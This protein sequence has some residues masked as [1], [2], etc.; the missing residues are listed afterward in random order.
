MSSLHIRLAA[1]NAAANPTRA[2]V[3][4][5]AAFGDGVACGHVDGSIW[6]YSLTGPATQPE[7]DGPGDAGE[8]RLY[9]KCMLAGHRAAIAL[10]SLAE[11]SS[12]TPEGREGALISVSEDGDVMVWSTADGQ[13]ISRVQTPLS[14]IRP[15][16]MC[17]QATDYQS[18]AEN[19]L[20]IA[21]E[22]R[23]AYVLSYPSLELVHEWV[24]P[25]PEWITALAVRKRRDWFRTELI[26]CASDG[27]VRIW[28][29]D[30][31]APAQQD[32]VSRAAS[33]VPEAQVDNGSAESEPQGRAKICLESQFAALGAESAIRMLVVNPFNDDEFLAVSPKTVRLFA[34][35]SSELHELLRWRPQRSTESSFVGG[36]FLAKSDIIFWDAA[37]TIY[38][39][40]TLFSIEGGSAGMHM[41]RGQHA[42]GGSSSPFFVAAGLSAVLPGS[43]LGRAS[44]QR[45][46]AGTGA[47]SVLATYSSSHDKHTLSL[48][49]PVPLSSVSGSANR[50]HQSPADAEGGPRNWLGRTALFSMGPLWHEWLQ[51]VVLEREITSVLAMRDGC[52]AIGHGDGTIQMMPPSSLIGGL[53][54]STR[55]K[56]C[57]KDCGKGGGKDGGNGV[58]VLSGHEGAVTALLEWHPPGA[59]QQQSRESL[60]LG[61]PERAPEP[62][63][64]SS[65]LISA[66]KDLA[67]RIWSVATGECLYTL[68]AQSAPVEALHA[69]EPDHAMVRGSEAQCRTLGGLLGSLV[70]AVGS[71][72]S[73]TLV[74]V[75]SFERVCVTAPYRARPVR[76]SLDR[77]TGALELQYSNNSRRR[78]GADYLAGGGDGGRWREWS[79]NL[80]T[81]PSQLACGG[82]NDSSS[83]SGGGGRWL[84]VGLL[85]PRG[86]APG[87]RRQPCASAAVLT[88]D[89]DVTQ[90]HT[91]VSRMVG[92]GVS[93][94]EM[95]QLLD[96]DD[97]QPLRAS[98]ELL[99]RLC[100]WGVSAE[101]DAVKASE[102]GMHQRPHNMS[103]TLSNKVVGASTTLFPSPASCGASWCMSSTLN[104]QRTLAI[105]L[106]AQGILQGNERRAVEVINFYVGRLPAQVGRQFKP[107]S[108]MEL[109]QYWQTANGNLQRAARTLV[110]SAVHRASEKQRR[111]EL[112]YWSSKLAAYAPGVVDSE[113]LRALAI[114]CV[115][116]A[117]FPALLPLTARSM[118]AAMLQALVVADRA[119]GVGARTVAIELLSRGFATF[120]PYLDCQ[121]V[122]RRLMAAMASVSETGG[123]ENGGQQPQ[124]QPP[125]LE[126][127]HQR[128]RRAVSGAM[129]AGGLAPGEER[130]AESDGGLRA[131]PGRSGSMGAEDGRGRGPGHGRGCETGVS[132]ALVGLAKAALLR[133]CATD[134]GLV[135]MTVC[136]MLQGP[137]LGV[138]E[139]RQALQAVGVVV[140]K[141]PAQL[142]AHVE[143]VAG[144]I[145][146]AIDPKRASVRR[147]LIG[148]AGAALQALVRAYPWV[149]F[150]ADTQCLVVGCSDGR[151]VAFD[152]RTATRTAVF[153]SGARTV[154][155]VAIAPR[156]DRVTSFALGNGTLSVWDPSPSA[157]AMFARSL[158]GP[159]DGADGSVAPTKSMAIPAGFLGHAA[160]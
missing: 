88:V 60:G 153:D 107:L 28:S 67:L 18:A 76:L 69:V 84:G 7:A 75:G 26:T 136:E 6:L 9:P 74:S 92:D 145:V 71:D 29:F 10:L 54:D 89:I 37:G 31:C 120:R 77:S 99:S 11:I 98:L 34:S 155:A 95:R 83:S 104:S 65:L 36:G 39:V 146:A 49:M 72:N 159:G 91:A 143:A 73:V 147:R 135:V 117:D 149:S 12:P 126:L 93:V 57:G 44:G 81:R 16:S 59:P 82:G 25:H 50:P 142:G 122:L 90:L 47:T 94:E 45:S 68:P 33:P 102:F 132:F 148:A 53:F 48:V 21:G 124:S 24:L 51:D 30:D 23:I 41:A 43:V 114:V 13:C 130:A 4:A 86:D 139:R 15:T 27:V 134:M 19:Q 152:L 80:E 63:D 103:L 150:H 137:G 160:N 70:L 64:A 133:I 111:A 35:R 115:I 113:G 1:W 85:P 55:G 20:F 17:L 87:R 158:F 131:R 2:K 118:A 42:E 154:A 127:E 52:I 128:R 38:S 157:L 100:S 46:G 62:A 106:L 129:W 8:L 140:H 5:V 78:I 3:A 14:G 151:C 119:V 144:A 97:G 56:D 61:N 141:Y 138:D 79:V 112:F 105:L 110:L 108:L 109:A 66:G 40:C 156:G 22:G 116:S 123:D 121:L 32:V 96:R 58:R 125:G 101:L